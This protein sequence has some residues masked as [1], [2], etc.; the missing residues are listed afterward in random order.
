MQAEWLSA[1]HGHFETAKL[2][3]SLG[4][5]WLNPRHVLNRLHAINLGKSAHDFLNLLVF[6]LWCAPSIVYSSIQYGHVQG[7][8][9]TSWQ[10]SSSPWHRRKMHPIIGT[11]WHLQGVSFDGSTARGFF[12]VLADSVLGHPYGAKQQETLGFHLYPLL[13]RGK[14][15]E[16]NVALECFGWEENIWY[17]LVNIQKAIE[18]CHR[19]SGFTY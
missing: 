12:R 1:R 7:A 8:G 11:C 13:Q 19:N 3:G 4:L 9:T 14:V 15:P 2:R 17:P 6:E 5:T 18:N 10:S 16:V